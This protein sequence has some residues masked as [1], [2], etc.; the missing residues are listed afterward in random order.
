MRSLPLLLLTTLQATPP[1]ATL[2][3][4]LVRIDRLQ[5]WGVNGVGMQA[6]LTQLFR[7]AGV[8][9]GLHCCVLPM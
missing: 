6:E 3:P 8:L 7:L 9:V 5:G 4:Q 2:R 1:L